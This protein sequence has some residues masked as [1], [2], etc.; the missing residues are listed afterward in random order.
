VVYKSGEAN[1]I[2]YPFDKLR[3]M[4]EK[5]WVYRFLITHNLFLRT[6]QQINLGKVMGFNTVRQQLLPKFDRVV[7][8]V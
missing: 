2:K 3:K 6:P 8:K 1:N 5:H 7:P 4:A